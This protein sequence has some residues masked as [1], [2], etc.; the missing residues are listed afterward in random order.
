MTT[1]HFDLK[2]V[3]DTPEKAISIARSLGMKALFVPYLDAADR[4]STA[5]GW[6][7]LASAFKKQANQSETRDCPLVGT[8]TISNLKVLRRY[9]SPRPDP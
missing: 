6:L 9:A 3:E 7:A 8:T 1:G 5:E 2:M 4:P